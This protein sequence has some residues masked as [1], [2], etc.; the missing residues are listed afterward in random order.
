MNESKP[1]HQQPDPGWCGDPQRGA[2][3]GRYSDLDPNTDQSLML[4]GVRLI[5]DYDE[6][7]AYWGGGHGT[8][9]LWIVW[10]PQTSEESYVRAWSEEEAK[11]QFPNANFLPSLHHPYIEDFFEG[12]VTAALWSSTGDDPDWEGD[13]SSNPGGVP[14]DDAHSAE[15]LA[16]SCGA[17]MREDCVKFLTACA[18]V[19][20]S[21][22]FRH[23]GSR[24]YECAGH[25]FWLTRNGPGAGF[26]DGDWSKPEAEELTRVSR[27]MGGVDLYVGDDGR[28]HC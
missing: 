19:L 11:A 28:I 21:A 10:D 14:L 12:Y 16:P 6:G 8:P 23:S 2:S 15:D 22:S 26:W 7:G 9:P 18:Q 24:R 5:G 27:E 3:M 1:R 4:K 13:P 17:Q 25:D 20:A